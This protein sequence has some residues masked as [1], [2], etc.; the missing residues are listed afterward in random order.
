MT[1]DANDPRLTAY[2][3][4]ELDAAERAETDR[5]LEQDV[6]ARLEVDEIRAAAKQLT[7][8]LQAEP[9][10]A[11]SDQ[12]RERIEQSAAAAKFA[13]SPFVFW[14][15]WAGVGLAAAA[16][17]AVVL[18]VPGIR[19]DRA[20]RESAIAM[21]RGDK[22]RS[23][24][25]LPAGG[26]G[27]VDDK[28]A[29]SRELQP[30]FENAPAISLGQALVRE[31]VGALESASVPFVES[32]D[33]AMRRAGIAPESATLADSLAAHDAASD[34]VDEALVLRVEVEAQGE[35][36]GRP[37]TAGY[38]AVAA[39]IAPVAQPSGSGTTLHFGIGGGGGGRG[40]AAGTELAERGSTITWQQPGDDGA[41]GHIVIV[42][43]D[44]AQ[45]QAYRFLIEEA[46]R[47]QEA[48]GLPNT[49][50]YAAIVDNPFLAARENPLSTFSIDV[51]TASY[52]NVRRFLTQNMLPPPD[53][54]RIEELLNYFRYDY[55]PPAPGHPDPFAAHIEVGPCPWQ[56]AHRL[57]RVGLKGREVAMDQ[58]PATNLVFLIDVSGSMQPENKLPLLK[59]S[60]KLLVDQL[61]GDDR[62]AIV[63]YAGNSGLAL[64]STYVSEK[65]TILSAIDQCQ[66]GG[67]T[68]GAAGIQLAYDIAQQHF[69]KGGINRVVLATDGDFNVGVSDEG[70]LLRLIEEK[71]TSGVSL[72]VLG[73][74]EGNLQDAKMELLADK[75]NGNYA[76]IDSLREGRKV[77]V[78]EA[79]GT[80]ITIA[81]DVKIQVEFNPA[82]VSAYRLI[83]Y[84]NRVLAAQDFNDDRKDAGE[85]G[86]GHEVTALYEIVPIGKPMP[87]VA[88]PVDPLKYQPSPAAPQES[89]A[90]PMP[91]AAFSGELLTLKLRYKQPDGD[92][93]KLIQFPVKDD[94]DEAAPARPGS[95]DFQFASAVAAFGM[96]LRD[97]PYRGAAT[98]ALALDL[99]QGGKGADA[100]GY[101]AEFITLIEQARSLKGE[102][103]QSP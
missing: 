50:N 86:T 68:N 23:M 29:A 48:L 103:A 41:L 83:G 31:K 78:E 92:E 12:Q 14:R 73:F 90:P 66:A 9:A 53:A 59:E 21:W 56:P 33:V 35:S 18:A 5:L 55:T 17:L 70:G 64:P 58:R 100:E 15:V 19:A 74:G 4:G 54:V 20:E 63:T 77:L 85:I 1:F 67:S 43:N 27:P 99:A 79:S 2:V 89:P 7:S 80:L 3:L 52:A 87:S 96:I 26:Q 25:G 34:G 75:G 95:T 11:M 62:L 84:E 37:A 60:M 30:S 65:A 51:D 44:P 97:S 22:D 39:P 13:P 91:G 38:P 93:S 81:K 102:T 47:Q 49:E 42:P 69:I 6:E 72:S 28:Q 88:P 8:A 57:V 45:E 71:R 94:A 24:L 10:S 101:R 46:R 16:C 98:F 61:H 76:Y 36:A 32:P 82:E 40:R